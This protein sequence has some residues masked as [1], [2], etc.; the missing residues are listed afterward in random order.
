MECDS[1]LSVEKTLA[2][3]KPILPDTKNLA[4][5][6]KTLARYN[7]SIFGWA[8]HTKEGKTFTNVSGKSFS[9]LF[10]LDRAR[11]DVS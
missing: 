6:K 7:N 10:P 1:D 5:Y 8:G 4:R 3:Y 11:S 9:P 2:R